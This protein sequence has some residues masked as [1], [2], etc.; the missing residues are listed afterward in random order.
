MT[1]YYMTVRGTWG[2]LPRHI[3]HGVCNIIDNRELHAYMGD[4]GIAAEREVSG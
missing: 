1:G 3:Y 4:F 2:K